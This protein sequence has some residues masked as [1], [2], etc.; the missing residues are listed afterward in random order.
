LASAEALCLDGED[1]F[2]DGS[3]VVL[4][5]HLL[6]TELHVDEVVS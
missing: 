1:V 4:L 2:L 3:G 6:A 5:V